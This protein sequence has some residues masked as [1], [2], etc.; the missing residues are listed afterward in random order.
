MKDWFLEPSR[1]W[2]L[3]VVLAL[4]V[5]Y[6]IVQMTRPRYTVRFSNLELL[7]KVA[8][9]RPGWRRHLVAGVF[10][11]ALA[12]L[13][14]A[15][16][17]PVQTVRVP[18]ER[19]TIILAI[20]TSRSMQADDVAPNR[21]AAAQR[22]AKRFVD[23]LPKRLNVGL[24]SFAGSAQLLVPPTTN[25]AAVNQSIDGLKLADSTAIGD[26]VKLSLQVIADQ[27]KGTDGKKPD[28]AIVLIS[29]GETTVGLPTQDAVPLAK[30][31]KVA[32]S[33]IAYGTADGT[34]TVDENGDG[35]G[36]R[37]RVPV[38]VD[39]LHD[40]ATGTG[41]TAYTAESA[42]D[43]DSVYAKLGSTIGYDKEPK[44]VSYRFVGFGVVA[45][46]AAA[47]LSLRWF[48]RVP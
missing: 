14:L 29:D 18:R 8:P 26:A 2:F 12:A 40:L 13:I 41:G 6:V 46:L 21:L 9:R 19:S 39:E 20:D 10:G 28:A 36:Q 15:F 43:L 25:H 11:L 31:A 37:V 17:Q 30:A 45:M 32:V 42:S 22:S 34:I 35:V 44:D 48:N 3:L 33:T 7:D 47:A 27:A 16:A 23:Q 1:L 38:N 4:V 5:V 24:V